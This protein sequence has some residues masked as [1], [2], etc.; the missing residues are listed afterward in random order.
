MTSET[1]PTRRFTKAA[2]DYDKYRPSYPPALFDW[3][4]SRA[5]VRQG[6]RVADVGCGT[7]I[8]TRLL[9]SRGLSVVGVEPNAA[10]LEKARARGGEF[11]V[12]KAEATGLPDASCALVTVAQAFHWF[13]IDAAL[14]EFK[15]ILK[16]HGRVAAFWNDRTEETP[17]L[18]GYEDLLMRRS[19]EYR[20]L[21]GKEAAIRAIS[22]S[23]RVSDLLRAEF[24]SSQVMDEEAFLGRV[25]S[26]SYVVHGLDDRGAFD[27]ELKA[28][29]A[30]HQKDG[31]VEFRYRTVVLLWRPA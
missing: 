9:A 16:P 14:A 21:P 30:A 8:S 7:G 28:L 24:P 23:R 12:G 2:D 26:S 10:M 22:S 18:R 13:D 11:V 29:F 3:M 17:F 15:R 4:L 5:G 6:A 31:T 1:E 27:A 20:A 25:R 19:S